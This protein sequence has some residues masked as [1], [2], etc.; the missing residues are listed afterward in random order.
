MGAYDSIFARCNCDWPDDER[1]RALP[2]D[3]TRWFNHLLW[4]ESV[5]QKSSILPSRFDAAYWS[6]RMAVSVDRV[7]EMVKAM[8]GESLVGWSTDGCLVVLGT[9]INHP[10]LVWAVPEPDEILNP[11]KKTSGWG[12]L[13]KI[14]KSPDTLPIPPDTVSYPEKSPDMVANPVK[15]PTVENREYREYRENTHSTEKG[16]RSDRDPLLHEKKQ[17][18][19][20]QWNKMA[21][22]R[23]WPKVSKIPAGATGDLLTAR[24][25]EDWW[26]EH[27]PD[28]IAKLWTLRWPDDPKRMKD[29]KK[30]LRFVAMLRQDAVRAVIDGEWNDAPQEQERK[31]GG[32]WALTEAEAEALMNG[33]AKK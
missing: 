14:A 17:W 2:D 5:R 12:I 21:T 4:L 1:C 7:E 22:D 9:E 20:D 24:C 18:A 19:C 27:Y 16:G 10:K 3:Q 33:S 11:F 25:K 15:S 26:V 30:G 6:K 23:G 28:A 29:G 32:S 13:A 8:A 31:E